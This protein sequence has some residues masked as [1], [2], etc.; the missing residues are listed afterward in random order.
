MEGNQ[1]QKR[2]QLGSRYIH[3]QDS[4][5]QDTQ[6]PELEILLVLFPKPCLGG[7]DS[8]ESM[9]QAWTIRTRKDRIYTLYA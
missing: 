7:E 3:T 1:P 5:Y 2:G 8:W 9:E 4:T 6:G